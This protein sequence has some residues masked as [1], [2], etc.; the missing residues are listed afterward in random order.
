MQDLKRSVISCVTLVMSVLLSCHASNNESNEQVIYDQRQQGDLNVHV[1]VSDVG[2]LAFLDESLFGEYGQYDYSYDYTDPVDPDD[3]GK[4]SN[5]TTPSSTEGPTTSSTTT[6][7]P[8]VA[9]NEQGNASTST[10]QYSTDNDLRMNETIP[11]TPISTTTTTTATKA[12]EDPSTTS[13]KSII[14]MLL[15]VVQTDGSKKQS[16]RRRCGPGYVRDNRGR[17]RR[18]RKPNYQALQRLPFEFPLEL[19]LAEHQRTGLE[20]GYLRGLQYQNKEIGSD[21]VDSRP[22]PPELVPSNRCGTE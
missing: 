21:N 18:V 12:P 20:S 3:N 19:K 5:S 7:T 14:A 17:C 22:K 15:P 16:G 8:T 1:H 10:T 11:T 13:T 4:P 6:V 9:S 2:I